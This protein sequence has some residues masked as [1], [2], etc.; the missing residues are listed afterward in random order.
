M[1]KEG[2]C[3]FTP[4]VRYIYTDGSLHHLAYVREQL[5][6]DVL[7]D[8]DG[9][10][11]RDYLG[12]WAKTL[13]VN[14]AEYWAIILA[15]R[16]AIHIGVEQAIILSDSELVIRQLNGRY[17]VRKPSLR[18]LYNKVQDLLKQIEAVF[19]YVPREKNKAG[20]LLDGIKREGKKLALYGA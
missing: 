5:E 15:L 7:R 18:V 1:K 2:K 9:V 6:R 20:W 3:L 16:D 4:L 12:S 17:A 11:P 13:T 14:E 8:V 19:E 10:F